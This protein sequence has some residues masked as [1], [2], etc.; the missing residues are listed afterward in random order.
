L[1]SL[2]R[3]NIMY[4]IIEAELCLGKANYDLHALISGVQQQVNPY[5]KTETRILYSRKD[6]ESFDTVDYETVFYYQ[7]F[8]MFVGEGNYTEALKSIEFLRRKMPT[9]VAPYLSDAVN[10]LHLHFN[11]G[12]RY[13]YPFRKNT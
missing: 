10:Y 7:L 9:K 4:Y 5:F 8:S 12:K 3:L 6:Q 13:L 2:N 11:F 1:D